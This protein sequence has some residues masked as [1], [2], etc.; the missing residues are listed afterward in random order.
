M[1]TLELARAGAAA[2]RALLALGPG[3]KDGALALAAAR[4]REGSGRIFAANEADLAA[5]RAAGLAPP[6]LKRLTY[7]EGK[8]AESLAMLAAL[9]RLP[10]PAGRILEARRL[11]AGLEL[12]RISCPIGLVALV[13]ESRP[14]ALV[15]M[16]GLAIKSGNAIVAKGGREAERTNR[17]LAAL[18]AAAGAE[19]GLPAGWLSCL[20]T[21]E[22]VAELLA[23]DRYVDLVIPRGS[24][25]F[26]RRIQESSRIPV[27]GHSDG[28]C[29]LYVH[30]DADVAM[31][32]ALA[33]DSKAQYPAACNAAEVL[34]V[35]SGIAQRA[36]P[37]IAAALESASVRLELCP[38]SLA[39]LGP[40]PGRSPKGGGD[41]A[42]EYLDLVM[43][44]KVVGSLDEAIAHVN[45]FGSGHTDAIATSSREAARRFMAEVDSASVY[46]NASTRFADGYRYGL[47]AELG[48]STGKLHARGPMGLEGLMTYKWLLEGSGQ[49]VADYASGSR[50]F[51]HAELPE[52]RGKRYGGN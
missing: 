47:G 6:L 41:W 48:I 26:V 35:H 22:E 2:A 3:I 15:Q 52:E 7:D 43:A 45:E 9:A 27:L 8:L 18:L 17:E 24:K 51:E 11:D 33:L 1:D 42:V 20:E 49:L 44:V 30:E 38:R 36:L 12:R 46:W 5:A 37:A 25:Q 39:I 31:A 50:R 4:L 14:D 40:G 29:H 16:A 13:F 32:S 28:I 23:L 19:A 21:R 34:L 10:D